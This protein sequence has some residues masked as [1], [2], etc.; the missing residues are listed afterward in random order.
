MKNKIIGFT[1]LILVIAFIIGSFTISGL[2]GSTDHAL[3]ERSNDT[4]SLFV[5]VENITPSN[6]NNGHYKRTIRNQCNT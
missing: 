5:D 2:L 1:Q 4:R 3:R 6:S